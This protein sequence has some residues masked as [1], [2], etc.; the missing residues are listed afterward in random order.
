[1]NGDFS[2]AKHVSFIAMY[3]QFPFTQAVILFNHDST[4]A[5]NSSVFL[6]YQFDSLGSANR[7][8]NNLY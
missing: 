7:F 6:C 3:Q 1:M 4:A 5:M 8:K 2:F